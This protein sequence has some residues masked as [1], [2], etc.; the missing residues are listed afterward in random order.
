MLIVSWMEIQKTTIQMKRQKNILNLRKVQIAKVNS[1]KIV[2]G[3]ETEET[4]PASTEICLVA[5]RT[6]KTPKT[7]TFSNALDCNEASANS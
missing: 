4:L 6:I 5:S 3:N 2:G 7:Q 1:H